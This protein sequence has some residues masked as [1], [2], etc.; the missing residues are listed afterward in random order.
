VLAQVHLLPP[1]LALQHKDIEAVALSWMGRLVTRRHNS[2]LWPNK[3]A[4]RGGGGR[5]RSLGGEERQWRC[6][7]EPASWSFAIFFKQPNIFIDGGG[8]CG[9][10]VSGNCVG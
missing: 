6:D 9:F 10:L 2:V 5:L 7:Y 1:P 4:A 8:S 3:S